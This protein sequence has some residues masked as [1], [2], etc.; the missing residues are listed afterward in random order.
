MKLIVNFVLEINCSILSWL[1]LLC[2][3]MSN[4]V[5]KNKVDAWICLRHFISSFC[6]EC[7]YIRLF[8]HYL[9]V[10]SLLICLICTNSI[11]PLVAIY[12]FYGVYDM[13]HSLWL[14]I[15]YV[16]LHTQTWFLVG[17]RTMHYYV[18]S[19]SSFF[20]YIS[21]T[22]TASRDPL[23]PLDHMLIFGASMKYVWLHLSC[24]LIC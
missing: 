8:I 10:K 7:I 1:N 23:D 24:S 6:C 5:M 18:C 13:L 3:F 14:Y 20:S 19:W 17:D 2:I 9:L 22:S 12:Q 15:C 11:Q 4:F 21:Y 16:A